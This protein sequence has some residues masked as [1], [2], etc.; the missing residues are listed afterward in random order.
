VRTHADLRKSVAA[1]LGDTSGDELTVFGED[2]VCGALQKAGAPRVRSTTR[3]K[4]AA[5]IVATLTWTTDRLTKLFALYSG[6]AAPPPKPKPA[7]TKAAA[8]PLPRP[9]PKPLPDQS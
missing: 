5:E 8:K 3:D 1:L 6:E 7:T 9:L 4:I 2:A